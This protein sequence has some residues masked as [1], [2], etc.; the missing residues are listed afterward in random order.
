MLSLRLQTGVH[1]VTIT[2]CIGILSVIQ[3]QAEVTKV[4]LCDKR[5]ASWL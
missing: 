5:A 4:S 3:R 2:V 1:I